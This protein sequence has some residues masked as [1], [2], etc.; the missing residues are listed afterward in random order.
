[1]YSLTANPRWPVVYKN[2][3]WEKIKG[4]CRIGIYEQA[5]ASLYLQ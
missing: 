3:S 2:A 1:M 4:K 5:T